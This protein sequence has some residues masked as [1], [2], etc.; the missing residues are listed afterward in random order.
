MA[1][2]SKLFRSL[3]P[4]VDG[5]VLDT[6]VVS[7]PPLSA[8]SLAVVLRAR[9]IAGTKPGFGNSRDIFNVCPYEI[10][11]PSCTS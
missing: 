1:N 6:G 8:A 2:V 10:V 5:N 9:Q 7:I 4:Q 3:V 11:G